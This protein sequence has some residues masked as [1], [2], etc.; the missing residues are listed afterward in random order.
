MGGAPYKSAKEGGGGYSF[1]FNHERAPICHVYSD[2]MSSKQII[3]QLRTT[4]P[5]VSLKLS[6]DSTQHSEW[7]HFTMTYRS[8][9]RISYVHLR[10]DAL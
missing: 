8:T 3:G 1:V 5:P 6:P 7:H 10:K 4:K 2:F 9:H